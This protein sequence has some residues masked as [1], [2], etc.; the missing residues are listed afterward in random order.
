MFTWVFS[1][2][3]SYLLSCFFHL[4]VNLRNISKG[5]PSLLTFVL[6]SIVSLDHKASKQSTPCVCVCVC[7]CADVCVCACVCARTCA[8]SAAQLC[9]TLR[10]PW[11]VACEAPLSMRLS[12]QECWSELPF[13]PPGDLLDPGWNPIVM[14]LQKKKSFYKPL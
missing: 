4:P 6:Y 13:P 12:R 5:V 9:P 1:E 11:T 10:D 7:V 14:L 8:R 2:F 3:C